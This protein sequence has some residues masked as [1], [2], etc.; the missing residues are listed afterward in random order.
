MHGLCILFELRIPIGLHFIPDGI[1]LLVSHFHL[2]LKAGKPSKQ[3]ATPR[4]FLWL[5]SGPVL[6]LSRSHERLEQLVVI[7]VV[8]LER[9]WE[10]EILQFRVC[11][12]SNLAA[13]AGPTIH[14]L[15]K[16]RGVKV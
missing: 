14:S 10:H 13:L 1:V 5:V 15:H 12:I 4:F 16:G 6:H 8:L 7:K 9:F 2:I 3:V 11:Y